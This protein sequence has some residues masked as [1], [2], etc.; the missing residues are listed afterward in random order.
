MKKY[1][2]LSILLSIVF[3]SYAGF[4]MGTQLGL[5]VA[6]LKNTSYTVNSK[7]VWHGGLLASIPLCKHVSVMP[8]ILYSQ[9]G[10]KYERSTSATTTINPD[11][12]TTINY[13]E[14]VNS[15][16][17]YLEFPVLLTIFS[18][19][20]KGL[21]LQ[22]GPQYSYLISNSTVLTSSSTISTNGGAAQPTS[23]DPSSKLEFNKSDVSLVGG[24]G[25]RF[26]ILLMIYARISTGFLKVQQGTL[27]KDEDSGRHF[28]LEI[29]AALTF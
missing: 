8:A 9:R 7:I 23:P 16:L 3:N 4:F 27:V 28:A 2:C 6:T 21:M 14:S 5:N 10:F 13:T 19:H 12:T 15:V 18:G 11:T 20:S 22:V 17:G 24:L 1:I 26:P 29:G 25:L